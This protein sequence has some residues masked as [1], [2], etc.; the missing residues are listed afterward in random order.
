MVGHMVSGPSGRAHQRL[1]EHAII[2]AMKNAIG[3][4]RRPA[5]SAMTPRNGAVRAVTTRQS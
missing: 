5:L 1:K 2:K 4:L 3:G